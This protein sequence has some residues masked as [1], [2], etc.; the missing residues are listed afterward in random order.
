MRYLLGWSVLCTSR[1]YLIARVRAVS[2]DAS[3][4]RL[5]DAWTAASFPLTQSLT[6]AVGS[7]LNARYALLTWLFT[8]RLDAGTAANTW[9]RANFACKWQPGPRGLDQPCSAAAADHKLCQLEQHQHQPP[10]LARCAQHAL[11]QHLAVEFQ[12]MSASYSLAALSDSQLFSLSSR[13]SGA[14][15]NVWWQRQWQRRNSALPQVCGAPVQEDARAQRLTQRA[16]AR[17]VRFSSAHRCATLLH[18]VLNTLVMHKPAAVGTFDAPLPLSSSPFI[19]L[20]AIPPR[21]FEDM[22]KRIK[23]SGGSLCAISL[24]FPFV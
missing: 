6:P 17:C 20:Q 11:A 13:F 22:A 3:V 7:P 10:G 9:H 19:D 5:E 16:P 23:A 21:M 1:L 24:L 8:A 2:L 12:R 15:A 18:R 14:F 4:Q